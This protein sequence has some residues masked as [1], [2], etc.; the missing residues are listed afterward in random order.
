MAKA[1]TRSRSAKRPEPKAPARRPSRPSPL[2]AFAQRN[3]MPLAGGTAFL[4]ALSF[5]SANALW[6]QPHKHLGAFFATRGAPV[7]ASDTRPEFLPPPVQP[8]PVVGEVQT[9]LK[10]LGLYE[11]AIDGVPGSGTRKAIAVFQ[12]EAGLE[13]TGLIDTRLMLALSAAR[14]APQTSAL[15]PPMS[16]APESTGAIAPAPKPEEPVDIRLI[17]QGLRAFGN[18][19][20]AV[21]G[22]AGT[23]TR[24]GIR[25]FQGMFGLP[26]TG[27]PTADVL[28]KMREA[29]FLPRG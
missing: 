15:E 5:V 29:G 21:D 24:A 7:E 17:Q 25:A 9:Q 6:G 18:E 10:A 26:E 20:I 8:D 27:E 1:Q 12:A 16:V 23:Q 13:P 14:G 2:L 19:G 3:P 4:V 28:A 11:G 22:V